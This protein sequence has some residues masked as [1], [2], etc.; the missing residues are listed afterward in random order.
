[1]F[2]ASSSVHFVVYCNFI[3]PTHDQTTFLDCCDFVEQ[4]FHEAELTSI[5]FVQMNNCICLVVELMY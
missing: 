2:I 5:G 4:S 3:V 1:M